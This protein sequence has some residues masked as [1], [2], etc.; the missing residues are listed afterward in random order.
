MRILLLLLIL[1]SPAAYSD[2]VYKCT[3]QSGRIVYQPSPC[4]GADKQRLLTIPSDPQANVEA[5]AKLDAVQQ[6]YDARKREQQSLE[7]QQSQRQREAAALEIARQ[8]AIAQ[9]QQ[10][11]AQ[12]RQAEALERQN[13]R[14]GGF[15]YPYYYGMPRPAPIPHPSPGQQDSEPNQRHPW[16]NY[17]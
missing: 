12:Q 3:D 10:A 6:E 14:S 15:N 8:N 7:Q 2:A 5:K 16:K 1:L 17:Q 11:I 4:S 13:R 9:Q